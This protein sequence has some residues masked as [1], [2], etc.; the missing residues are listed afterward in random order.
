MCDKLKVAS[1]VDDE[2]ISFTSSLYIAISKSKV[3]TVAELKVYL[4]QNPITFIHKLATESVKTVD[5]T[6]VNEKGET[7]HFMPLEGT[8]SVQSSGE[9]I[10]PTFD[11]SVPVEATTQNLASFIDMEMGE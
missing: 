2:I 10:Q 1:G 6:T 11:M 9:I 3:S 4:S 5:L 8:M 7:T